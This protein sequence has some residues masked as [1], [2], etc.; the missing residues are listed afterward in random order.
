ME[1]VY[2]FKLQRRSEPA[3]GSDHRVASV[4]KVGR[5]LLQ[6]NERN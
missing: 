1:A 2:A 3:I 4:A 5:T 6:M